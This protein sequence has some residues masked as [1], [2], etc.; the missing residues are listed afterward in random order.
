MNKNK[1]NREGKKWVEANII[2][3]EQLSNILAMYKKEDRTYLLIIL[4]ALLIS[5]S[6]IVF[7]FSDWAQIP[8]AFKIVVMLGMMVFFYWYGHHSVSKRQ[9]TNDSSKRNEFIG[10][11]FILLGYMLF[12][13][14]LF[15]TLYMYDVT[16]FSAWPFVVWSV[17]GL[18][19]YMVSRS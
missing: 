15:L 8:S 9:R 1:L 7:I 18:F 14:T 10:I 3:E 2:S 4:A 16:L 17:L 12:G 5:I 6:M 19:L 13:T 11:S